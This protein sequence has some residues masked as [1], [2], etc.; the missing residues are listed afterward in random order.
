[1]YFLKSLVSK[2]IERW[3]YKMY[4]LFVESYSENDF[5]RI[6]ALFSRKNVDNEDNLFQQSFI[7][8]HTSSRK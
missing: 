8:L 4:V 6:F 5:L 1:M 7:K 3:N 2:N